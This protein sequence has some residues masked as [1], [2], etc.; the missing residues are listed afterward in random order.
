M[1]DHREDRAVACSQ[2]ALKADNSAASAIDKVITN[3]VDL[4]EDKGLHK[5]DLATARHHPPLSFRHPSP[6]CDQS[7]QQVEAPII[8]RVSTS[9]RR[10]IITSSV[11]AIMRISSG[12]DSNISLGF[13]C[14]SRRRLP[15][16]VLI[17]YCT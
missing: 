8:D 11:D 13:I 16:R 10:K 5:A 17:S 9:Y 7:A 6:D 12:P 15:S 3:P 1:A 2:E 14:A 4:E